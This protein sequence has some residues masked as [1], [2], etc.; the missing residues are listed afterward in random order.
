VRN[1]LSQSTNYHMLLVLIPY[2][3]R[4]RIIYALSSSK[5]T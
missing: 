2:L 3:V 4:S 5:E 1:L